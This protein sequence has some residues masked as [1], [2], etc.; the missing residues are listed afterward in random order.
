MAI[1]SPARPAALPALESGMRLTPDEFDRRHELRPDIY[2]AELIK[3]RVYVTVTV[4]FEKHG[5]PT[6][7][8]ET[9]IGVY[10]VTRETVMFA[11]N[12]TLRLT[13]SHRV[14]PD[15]LVWNTEG[16]NAWLTADDILSGAPEL[17]VEVTASS[18]DYDLGVKKD[19]YAEAGVQEYVV[20]LT[21]EERILWFEL[22]DGAYVELAADADG[23][24]RSRVFPG[25]ALDIPRLL[26]G[27]RTAVLG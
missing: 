22:V 19:A 6:G 5:V 16:G 3:G 2:K 8:A 4:G 17:A 11:S 25:L 7:L 10:A 14:Q 18:R 24:T 13:A 20:W 21:E 27:D 9:W 1:R 23:I 15:V 12:A 26:A